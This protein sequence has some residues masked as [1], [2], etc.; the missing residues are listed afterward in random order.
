MTGQLNNGEDRVCGENG[1]I[2]KWTVSEY[3]FEFT[4]SRICG[5]A[6]EDNSIAELEEIIEGSV[7][8]DGCANIAYDSYMHY[9]EPQQLVEQAE[10]LKWCYQ[11]AKELIP[12][13][14]IEGWAV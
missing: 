4:I 10:V 14:Q 9:C 11:K 8:W 7:K 3:L 5:R 1:F 2:V 6:V 13:N 12:N